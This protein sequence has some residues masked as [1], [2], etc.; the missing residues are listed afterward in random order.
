MQLEDLDNAVLAYERAIELEDDWM[1]RLNYAITLAKV[2]AQWP[3][4]GPPL[5]Y[6]PAAPFFA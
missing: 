2:W 6:V 4:A 5:F 3:S 1:F